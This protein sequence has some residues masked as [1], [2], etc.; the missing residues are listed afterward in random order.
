MLFI[1]LKLLVS[2]FL[3]FLFITLLICFQ[4]M[5]FINLFSTDG[6]NIIFFI[7]NEL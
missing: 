6:V 7:I 5:V 1:S 4:Q 3:F 2:F